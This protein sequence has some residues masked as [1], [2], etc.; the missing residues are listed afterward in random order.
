MLPTF[1]VIA[2]VIGVIALF[3]APQI[4]TALRR[5]RRKRRRG[6]DL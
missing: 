4:L 1:L 5:L 3:M 2:I 6:S